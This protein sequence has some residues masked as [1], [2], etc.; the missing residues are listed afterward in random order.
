MFHPPSQYYR[1][2]VICQSIGTLALVYAL[3]MTTLIP[4]AL[5]DIPEDLDGTRQSDDSSLDATNGLVA[6]ASYPEELLAPTTQNDDS[7]LEVGV[8][9]VVDYNQSGCPPFS[10]LPATEPDAYGLVNKLQDKSPFWPFWR[11]TP[12]WTER[13]FYGSSLAWEEDWKHQSLGG[14]EDSY[15]DTVDLAYF[16]GHGS[17]DGLLFGN[18]NHDDNLLS[19]SDARDA[20][21]NKDLDWVGLAACNVLDDPNLGQWADTLNGARLIMG[22]KTVMDDV[23][24]GEELGHYIRRNYT[25]TQAWFK[26]ADKLQSQGRIARV[27]AEETAYF[28]DRWS[29][30]RSST[31]VDNDYYYR[32]HYVGSEPARQVDLRQVTEM[33]ILAIQPLPLS[34]ASNKF[35]NVGNAFGSS[36]VNAA[37]VPA[38]VSGTGGITETVDAKLEMDLDTGLFIYMDTDRLW[39]EEVPNITA[40]NHAGVMAISSQDARAIAE[41]FLNENGLMPADAE[42]YEVTQ[43]TLTEVVRSDN[44]SNNRTGNGEGVM[45]ASTENILS[46]TTSNHNVIFSRIYSYTNPIM[47][48]Q[49]TQFSI[50]GPGAKLKV[51]VAPQ[52]TAGITAASIQN[53]AI[54]GGVG[55]YRPI[56]DPEIR[57]AQAGSA[58]ST[59]PVMPEETVETLFE[60]LEP[61]VALSHVPQPTA[62]KEILSKTLAYWEGPMGFGQ[63]EL[64]PVYAL[65]VRSTMDDGTQNEYD[66]YIPVNSEYLS[67]YAQI[68]ETG[69][70]SVS[71]NASIV[72]LEATDAS[73]TLAELGVDDSLN[74]VM[75]KGPFE[76]K[77]YLNNVSEENQLENAQ[78]GTEI[79]ENGR[80]ITHSMN[81]TDDQ[82]ILVITDT[83][84]IAEPRTSQTTY[85]L[86]QL[87]DGP[88]ATSFDPANNILLPV[89]NR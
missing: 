76:Y 22:F 38:A 81:S 27:L 12:K 37:A 71:G 5:A 78:D 4:A 15:I 42:F 6:Q 62:N 87:T 70:A 23:A 77:W 66:V 65:K 9:Y 11:S 28:N 18:C 34:E 84:K 73:K 46:E 49:T 63:L 17:T 53:E 61:F 69:P 3:L 72:T 56:I 86:T 32:T 67:P 33:P 16:A 41:D 31:T 2:K 29:D 45:A 39:K 74:F 24:H 36:T 57:A 25:M 14:S 59:T 19:F 30:H 40:A 51:F 13:F 83:G 44:R 58:V 80:I 26:A 43:D 88:R 82:I 89:I 20:W 47:P 55:G 48:T 8:W 10:N 75:G 52:V 85:Q 54:L 60:K 50:I 1:R 35:E 68:S 21:G 7:S 79:S 64:I